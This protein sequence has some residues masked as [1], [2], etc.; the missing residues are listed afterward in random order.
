M[1]NLTLIANL[2]S[3]LLLEPS[4]YK[5]LNNLCKVKCRRSTQFPP[6]LLITQ[7][8]NQTYS[9]HV[10]FRTITGSNQRSFKDNSQAQYEQF[11]KMKMR[12]KLFFF[13]KYLVVKNFKF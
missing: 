10:H 7:T 11:K 3:H 6:A 5:K 9:C 12:T 1:R 8:Y 4:T 13:K 2:P